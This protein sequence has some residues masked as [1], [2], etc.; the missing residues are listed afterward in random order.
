M[1][2][3]ISPASLTGS[4]GDLK[5]LCS[6]KMENPTASRNENE[7]LQGRG[8]YGGLPSGKLPQFDAFVSAGRDDVVAIRHEV[9]RRNVV[10][11]T[12]KAKFVSFDQLHR[13]PNAGKLA[14]DL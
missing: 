3:V 13:S 12:C 4:R 14:V 2:C 10:V 1:R 9:H 5:H 11:V 7:M 8:N 6:Q